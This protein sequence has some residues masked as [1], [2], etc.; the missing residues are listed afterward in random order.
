MWHESC[1]RWIL[2]D[3]W[4]SWTP[5]P[6]SNGI[7]WSNSDLP[8]KATSCFICQVAPMH[9]PPSTEFLQM[10]FTKWA[11]T[12]FIGVG[13]S[14][15]TWG[16][17]IGTSTF[18]LYCRTQKQANFIEFFRFVHNRILQLQLLTFCRFVPMQCNDCCCL[19]LSLL[20]SCD[21]CCLLDILSDLVNLGSDLWVRMSVGEFSQT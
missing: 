14:A 18:G 16:V 6:P 12:I 1:W 4:K 19:V 21:C 11:R 9:S 13:L 5:P 3:C 8:S 15:W 10:T 2:K 20:G 17:K 7:D